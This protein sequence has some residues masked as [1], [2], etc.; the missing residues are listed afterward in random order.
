VAN[1]DGILRP[2]QFVRVQLQGAQRASAITVPQRAV[3][4]GPMGKMVFVVSND[5][6]LVP[7]P[8]ELD[9]WTKGDWVVTKGLQDGEQVMVDG[10]IKAHDPGMLVKPI[11]LTAAQAANPSSGA[12]AASSSAAT[13]AATPSPAASH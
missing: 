9:A 3:R 6:K 5:N 1:P 12:P 7:R 8:V 2:G 11:L 4:D 10:F 13:S